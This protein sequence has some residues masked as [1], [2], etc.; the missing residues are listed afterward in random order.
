MIRYKIDILDE[1]K[2]AGYSSY[3][4]RN[5]KILSEGTIQKLRTGDTSI[6]VSVLNE[7]C[8]LL[9]CQP[10]DILEYMESNGTESE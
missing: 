3:R 7:I 1:L 6:T 9:D 10:G 4:M 5:K 8:N 2:K